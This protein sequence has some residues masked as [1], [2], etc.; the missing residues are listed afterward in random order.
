MEGVREYFGGVEMS[1]A[2]VGG[3]LMGGRPRRSRWAGVRGMSERSS[4]GRTKGR[5]A[6]RML[7]RG[8][9]RRVRGM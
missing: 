9:R 5:R 3:A 6:R 2:G 4:L 1:E 7:K 8:I